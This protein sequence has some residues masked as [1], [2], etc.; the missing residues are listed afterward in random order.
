[1]LLVLESKSAKIGGIISWSE[2]GF[3]YFL[4]GT[5][6]LMFNGI[7][8]IYNKILMLLSIV[9][10]LYIPY[11]LYF[12]FVKIKKW[13]PLCLVVQV[14]LFFEGLLSILSLVPT[15]KY[16]PNLIIGNVISLIII[17]SSF[18]IPLILWGFA[19]PL[20]K[21]AKEASVAIN[22]LNRI[23]NDPLIFNALLEN[24]IRLKSH[25]I[26]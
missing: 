22:S 20:I 6:F 24:K 13:C 25:Q 5:F 12:Q 10:L 3:S 18:F 23:K 15:Y 7:G 9:N 2:L 16:L 14:V 4:V 8:G 21:K 11:S 19:S 17:I 26:I 1:V